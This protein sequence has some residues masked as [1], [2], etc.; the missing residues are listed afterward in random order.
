MNPD[1]VAFVELCREAGIEIREMT[2]EELAEAELLIAELDALGEA[3][4]ED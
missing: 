4:Y 2:P 3:A 1:F